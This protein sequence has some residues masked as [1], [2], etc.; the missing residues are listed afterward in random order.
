M[1]F[2]SIIEKITKPRD[3]K[4]IINLSFK[5]YLI[6]VF[7]AVILGLLLCKFVGNATGDPAAVISNMF[8]WSATL[9]SPLVVILLINSWKSQK[10]YELRKEI[11]TKILNDT[12]SIEMYVIDALS[13]IKTI[14]DINNY[15]VIYS[16]YLS[17][18]PTDLLLE[19]KKSYANI[20]I[21]NELYDKDFGEKFSR[22]QIYCFRI[23]EHIKELNSSYSIYY[24]SVIEAFPDL[25]NVE[26]SNFKRLYPIEDFK[27]RF[28]NVIEL[29][30]NDLGEIKIEIL[31]T[32]TDSFIVYAEFKSL[33]ELV[34]DTKLLINDLQNNCINYLRV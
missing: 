12:H 20:K 8:V 19:I 5:I 14:K 24:Q 6:L 17:E 33:R 31:D 7:F 28:N 9:I 16:T 18:H 22:L 23:D 29:V 26:K 11:A 21:F 27:V 34:I 30:N 3:L 1:K 13:M 15:L 25:K 10:D 2:F 4:E 32:E